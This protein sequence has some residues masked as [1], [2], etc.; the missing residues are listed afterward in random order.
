[1]LR[2]IYTAASGMLAQGIRTDVL[3]NN[4]ANVDTSGYRRQAAE[5]QAFP[6]QLLM[7]QEKAKFT[8]IG[9]LG[10]GALVVGVHNSFLQG[11][12]H[13]TGNPFD[14]AIDGP[15]FFVID[16]PGQR[17]YTRDGSFTV[18][19]GGWLTTQDGFRVLGQNG[20]IYIGDASQVEINSEGLVIVDGVERDRLLIVEFPDRRGLVNQGGNRYHASAAAGLPFRYNASV[21][22]GS[23]EMANVNT[24]RE[25]V[26]LI[27]VQRAY[28]ANQKVIQ[29][30][31]ETLGKL[32]NEITI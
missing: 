7:R 30:F 1:L 12:I 26:N 5:L 18:N 15:G 32:V 17:S 24:V 23:I 29:A 14:I 9:R 10:T 19:V 21:I 13:T 4:L 11:R 20:P 31:D 22:Q 28:E 25:M 16:T 2:G 6:E 27:E 3:T 8:Q